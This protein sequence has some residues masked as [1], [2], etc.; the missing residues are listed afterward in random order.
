MVKRGM[1]ILCFG[2]TTVAG[3]DTQQVVEREVPLSTIPP[4]EI[5][6]WQVPKGEYHLVLLDA[7]PSATYT[8][9]VNYAY[10]TVPP[11]AIEPEA[12]PPPG[13]QA[14]EECT[15]VVKNLQDALLATTSEESVRR[16]VSLALGNVSD[17]CRPRVTQLIDTLTHRRL[18]IAVKVTNKYVSTV[19]VLRTSTLTGET[20]RWEIRLTT[21]P[22]AAWL[23]M[24]VLAIVQDKG[25]EW[26]SQ[27]DPL[28]NEDGT[29]QER[30]RL[31]R[32][33]RGLDAKPGAGAGFF[34]VPESQRDNPNLSGAYMFGLGI[35]DSETPLLVMIGGSLLFGDHVTVSLGLAG[36][37]ERELFGRYRSVTYV[38]TNLTNDQLTKEEIK[39]RPF[40][41]IGISFEGFDIAEGGKKRQPATE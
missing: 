41:A 39:A 37:W 38:E 26:F 30:F 12:P 7:L 11:P 3:A 33:D 18:P 32:E 1:L 28:V 22:G 21:G 10:R 34:F 15:T 25:E 20:R 6:E 40:F 23:T 36:T 14:D 5:V 19:N 35:N 13:I 31:V 29:T 17:S 27:S 4:N 8:S 16:E 2:V 9:F 24:P